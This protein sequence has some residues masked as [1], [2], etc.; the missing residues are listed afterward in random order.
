MNIN[1]LI[2]KYGEIGKLNENNIYMVI[3]EDRI[4]SYKTEPGFKVYSGLRTCSI[5]IREAMANTDI[6]TIGNVEFRI[7][8]SA[9]IRK[10]GIQVYSEALVFQ[11]DFVHEINIYKETLK[12]QGINLPEVSTQA[13]FT[14]KARVNTLTEQESLTYL[15]YGDKVPTHKFTIMPESSKPVEYTDVIK[16]GSRNFEVMGTQNIDEAGR[17]IVIDAVE[18]LE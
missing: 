1:N 7:F 3:D 2:T 10:K 4:S 17:F 5:I 16:W 18:G 9:A 11:D 13:P 6:V 14:Y 15:R 8:E 12:T